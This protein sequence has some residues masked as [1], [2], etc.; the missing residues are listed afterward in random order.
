[1]RFAIDVVFLDRD[2]HVVSVE[3]ELPAWRVA[4]R[5][6]A[7]AVLELRAGEARRRGIREGQAF[8]FGATENP[9]FPAGSPE[10]RG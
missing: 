6:G 3:H 8:A 10:L 1:M 5:K 9:P 4:A 2:D 7:K